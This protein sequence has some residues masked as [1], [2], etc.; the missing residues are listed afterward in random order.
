MGRSIEV[1]HTEIIIEVDVNDGVLDGYQTLFAMHSSGI[2]VIYHDG[3]SNQQIVPTR[4][5]MY[6]Q[7][8]SS[9]SAQGEITG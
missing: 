5:Y 2:R 8:D 9:G 4:K 1:P 7:R 3:L 6:F